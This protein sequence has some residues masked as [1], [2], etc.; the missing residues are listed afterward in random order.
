MYIIFDLDDTLIDTSGSIT[1]DAL[2]WVL[3]QVRPDL[4]LAQLL[5][6]NQTAYSSKEAFE[7]FLKKHQA[8]SSLDNA[9]NLM[10]QYPLKT[11]LATE[12]AH[13]ITKELAKDFTL[14]IVTVGDDAFQKLKLKL[15]G[16]DTHQFSSMHT[17]KTPNKKFIYE[18]LL[19]KWQIDPKKVLVV[20]DRIASDL[21]PAK[22]LGMKTVHFRFGRGRNRTGLKTDVDYI[23]DNLNELKRIAYEY[24]SQ[25]DE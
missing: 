13:E 16:F 12:S 9:L 11:A 10:H 8:L 7:A 25:N 18:K 21:Q 24:K 2:S 22:E 4:P 5:E 20:G 17:S 19:E 6:I 1:P 14:S 23:I 15:A 3:N